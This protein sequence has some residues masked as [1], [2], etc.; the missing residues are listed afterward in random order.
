MT[1]MGAQGEKAGR[2]LGSRLTGALTRVAKV[3]AIGAGVAIGAELTRGFRTGMD[4]QK[5]EATLR[6]L[7]GAGSDV[8]GMM[9]EI[10]DISTRSP[11]D[12]TAYLKA[13]EAFGYMGL[14]SE[15]VPTIL[16]NMGEAI[17]G[18][19]GGSEHIDRA[20]QALLKMV[21]Q[22]RVYQEDL[23]T[24]SDAGIPIIDAL[25]HHYGVTNQELQ[26]MITEGKVD[27]KSG[28]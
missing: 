28:V 16:R 25:A 15:Q 4:I 9:R 10:R 20:T 26:K 19:G 6:G 1:G 24:L 18:V 17:V 21:N 11:I 3:G 5:S 8:S 7:Y 27:R 14:N 13:A 12:Y 22:G 23:N 2:T